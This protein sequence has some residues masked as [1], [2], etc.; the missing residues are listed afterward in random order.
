MAAPVVPFP[1]PVQGGSAPSSPSRARRPLGLPE[2]VLAAWAL[3]LAGM[4]LG[5]GGALASYLF[6][7][8]AVLVGLVLHERAPVAYITFSL[9]LWWYTPFV[10]RVLNLRHGWNPTDA[11]LLAPQVVAVIAL[12]TVARYARDLRG[13]LYAPFV[14]VLIALAYAYAIGLVGGGLIPASYALLTWIAPLVF[15]VHLG[16]RWRRYPEIAAALRTVFA[17]FLPFMAAYGI[18]QFVVLPGWDRAWLVN[19]QMRSLGVPFPFLIRVF[20]T[21][22]TPGP[23]AAFLMVGAILGIQGKGVFRYPV[24]ALSL[25]AILLTR[26][27]AAWIAFILGLLLQTLSQPVLRLPKRTVTILVV[28]LLALPIVNSTQFKQS[29]L[30]RIAS[31]NNISG[32]ASFV[33]RLDFGESAASTI[34][35]DAEGTGLGNTGGA[36]KLRSTGGV[37]SLDNGFLEVFFIFGW[38][39]GAL[40]F[41]GL[42]GLLIQSL[43]FAEARRDPDAGSFRAC[44]VALVSILPVGEVFTGSSGTLLW[45]MI[46]LGLAAHA[47]HQTTGL[48]VRSRAWEATRSRMAMPGGG[49]FLPVPAP[50]SPLPTPVIPVR[51]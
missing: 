4:W 32:D 45:S 8:A 15:G 14:L 10:R 48:A 29:I 43:R 17:M 5:A 31:L 22:N 42:G 44:A 25:I 6:V 34:V 27:R 18:Y 50:A 51:R 28:A 21:L 9:S 40:F 23:Y 41:L 36:I 2:F 39:G 19:A 37:R 24:I 33:R 20:G 13:R 30:P 7:A 1:T 16:L 3:F 12:L 47:Y 11:T 26:T 49:T 46:G 35:N 38:V